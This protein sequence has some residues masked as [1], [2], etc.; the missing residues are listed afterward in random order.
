VQFRRIQ[1]APTFKKSLK[2]GQSDPDPLAGQ[3]QENVDEFKAC[4]LILIYINSCTRISTYHRSSL[5]PIEVFAL[6]T[7]PT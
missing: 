1:N 3:G 4:I 5:K 6:T 7:I 2:S